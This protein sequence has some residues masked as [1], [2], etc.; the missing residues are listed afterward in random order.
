[1]TLSPEEI[2]L[3]TELPGLLEYLTTLTPNEIAL[4]YSEGSYDTEG[5]FE[6]DKPS[7]NR[8]VSYREI[9][10]VAE[11]VAQQLR[12]AGI[13]PGDRVGILSNTRP[14]WI[15]AELA[16]YLV[17]A[18]VVTLYTSDSAE[19]N[20]Y[21][22]K[23][24]DVS[25]L[26]LE[27]KEQ[28]E[29]LARLFQR[30]F[31]IVS[32]S[33]EER[34]YSPILLKRIISFED[35]GRDSVSEIEIERLA[36]TELPKGARFER[37][38]NHPDDPATIIYTSGT[39]GLAK[40]VVATHAQ[41]LE[42]LRQILVSGLIDESR[43]ALH[44]LPQAHGFGMRMVHIT[45]LTGRESR[46]P[47]VSSTKSSQLTSLARELGQEDMK[48]AG[49]HIVPVVPKILQRIKDGILEEARKKSPK[50]ILLGAVIDTYL[51]IFLANQEGRE[52]HPKASVL[53]NILEA[54]P[55]GALGP[56]IKAALKKEIVGKEF[57]FFI[58]GGAALPSDLYDF[59]WALDLPVLEGY[60]STETNV[61]VTCNTMEHH[62][63]GTVGRVL[64]DDIELK[65]SPSGE[66]LIRSSSLASSYLNR[67]DATE[68]RFDKD[69]YYHT[70]DQAVIDGDGYLSIG[71]RIDDVIVTTSGENIQSQDLERSLCESEFIADAVVEGHR[72][73]HLVALVSIN[74][75]RVARHLHLDPSAEISLHNPNVIALIHDEIE[76]YNRERARRNVE[77]IRAFHLI[78]SLSVGDGLTPTLKVQ[79]AKVLSKYAMAVEE[80][81]EN[82]ERKAA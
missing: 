19:R 76:R 70:S 25:A 54:K 66:L 3:Q 15:I 75:E 7:Q 22:L 53:K 16:T 81:F 51:E 39:T 41:H 12:E 48:R 21:I 35:C 27:N 42:N 79:R 8:S 38:R 58:S 1:M 65:V 50:G 33:G 56:R 46:F 45:M 67:P 63:K 49:A 14:E 82:L 52:P 78:E 57:Q 36:Q 30:P 11:G 4:S 43:S 2:A 6:R 55:F 32:G 72:H 28:L 73:S 23:D 74:R 37:H 17:G 20:G 31:S 26:F 9:T 68:A 34:S 61:P 47:R 18:T 10:A 60:G 69:G 24:A 77:K 80:M 64:S 62:R 13:R 59:F 40:G 44:L 5:D 29:K 71:G